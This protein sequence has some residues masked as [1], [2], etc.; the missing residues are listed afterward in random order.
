MDNN[1]MYIDVRPGVL[2]ITAGIWTLGQV[3]YG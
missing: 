1:S 2:W 3:F